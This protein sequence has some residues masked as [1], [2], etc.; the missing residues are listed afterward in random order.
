M[1]IFF[2]NGL[3]INPEIAN[4]SVSISGD[5]GELDISDMVRMFLM[6]CYGMLQI[7]GVTAFIV[8]ELLRLN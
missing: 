4:T 6:K 2:Y 3:A 8:S 7:P 1:T 5:R